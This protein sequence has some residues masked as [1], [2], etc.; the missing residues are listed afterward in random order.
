MIKQQA[1]RFDPGKLNQDF[2]SFPKKVTQVKLI[3]RNS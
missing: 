1:I 3:Q 2:A